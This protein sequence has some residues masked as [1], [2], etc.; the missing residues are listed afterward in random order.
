MLYT[1][2]KVLKSTFH[3]CR[4]CDDHDIVFW[5]FGINY[6]KYVIFTEI[7]LLTFLFWICYKISQLWM[8]QMKAT[9]VCY[10]KIQYFGQINDIGFTFKYFQRW[11]PFVWWILNI[12]VSAYNAPGDYL[13]GMCYTP[14]WKVLKSTF[15]I[16]RYCDDH[17]I[18]FWVFGINYAKN[19]I[20]AEIT[21][22]TLLF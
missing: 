6:A 10:S 8:K 18:V 19:V 21:L 1:K 13:N 12:L 3:I 11:P 2:W 7:I 17:D 9:Y 15:H 5:V 4:Y 20:F 16:C 22:L 14:K